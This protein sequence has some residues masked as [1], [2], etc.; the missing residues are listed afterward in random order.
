MFDFQ[1][2][3]ALG[4]RSLGGPIPDP[5]HDTVKRFRWAGRRDDERV[6]AG[7]DPALIIEPPSV[8]EHDGLGCRCA[9]HRCEAGA[10]PA[11]GK[12]SVLWTSS[13]VERPTHP[14]AVQVGLSGVLQGCREAVQ[15][16]VDL[17]SQHPRGRRETQDRAGIPS[18]PSRERDSEQD[19]CAI[20][21]LRC[22]IVDTSSIA[23]M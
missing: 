3:P 5:A 16:I 12:K 7:V 13:V 8:L 23:G 15:E 6:S 18:I 22:A 1:S 9:V 20:S 14:A 21:R 19:A 11:M 4:R 10:G 2:R 17:D